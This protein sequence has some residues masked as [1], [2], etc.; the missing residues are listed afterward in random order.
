M[1]IKNQLFDVVLINNGCLLRD[2]HTRVLNALCAQNSQFLMLNQVVTVV[3][4]PLIVKLLSALTKVF[5]TRYT[6]SEEQITSDK[7]RN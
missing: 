4:T 6:I 7:R 3:T 2:N 1:Q 5:L